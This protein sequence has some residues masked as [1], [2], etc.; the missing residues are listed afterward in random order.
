MSFTMWTHNHTNGDHEVHRATVTISHWTT[1]L[2]SWTLSSALAA[3]KVLKKSILR[4]TDVSTAVSI[5]TSLDDRSRVF[6]RPFDFYKPVSSASRTRP[7]AFRIV[8]LDVARASILRLSNLTPLERRGNHSP[9]AS[10]PRLED[11]GQLRPDAIR[12]SRYRQVGYLPLPNMWPASQ[13]RN[14]DLQLFNGKA[15]LKQRNMKFWSTLVPSSK[16]LINQQNCV[17]WLIGRFRM[18]I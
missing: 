2:L 3:M 6:T 9:F 15:A 18:G 5:V 10:L 13:K 14:I 11:R 16:Y 12:I 1:A 8:P 4:S 7:F 17:G